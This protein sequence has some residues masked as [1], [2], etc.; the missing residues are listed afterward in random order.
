MVNW[1]TSVAGLVAALAQ[2]AKS[3]LPPDLAILAD[4]ISGLALAV[5]GYF[6]KDK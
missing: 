3:V 4:A 2:W 6:S 5:L 1:K